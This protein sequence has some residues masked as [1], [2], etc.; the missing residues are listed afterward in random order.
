MRKVHATSLSL[1]L[2]LLVVGAGACGKST[3][4][5]TVSGS[6]GSAGQSGGVSPGSRAG[7]AVGGLSAAAGGE[8]GK[9]GGS[10]AASVTGGTPAS[11]GGA[12]QGGAGSSGTPS[13]VAGSPSLGGRLASGGASAAVPATGGVRASG[14][15]VAGTPGSGGGS[16]KGGLVANGG[17]R[18]TG[19]M[20]AAGGSTGGATGGGGSAA[21]GATG[22]AGNVGTPNV[23]LDLATQYQTIEGFGF[24]GAQDNWWGSASDMW[25]DDWGTFVIN[26][27]GL[28]MW[29]NEY[30]SEEPNQDANWAK[31]KPVVQGFKKIADANRVPLKFILTVWSAP[32]S[33]KCTV[34]SVQAGQNPCTA[35][36]DGLKNGGT[37]DPTKYSAYADWL[38]QG[39]KNYADA[40][41]D[42]YAISPQ[43]E[44]MFVETYNSCVYDVDPTKLNSY[45]KMIE[46]VAPLVK[47]TYPNVKI[48]GQ[49]NMLGLEGQQW[50]Y[51]GNMDSPGWPNFDVLA[52]H[53]YQ[54]GV[55]PTAGSQLATYWAYVR[56][57]WAVPHNKNSWMTETSGYT[58]GW[59][60][61][62]GAKALGFAIYAA[63]NYGRASAWV[64][65]QG[66]ELGGPPNE[67]G[68][69]G[70]LQYLSKRYFVSKSFYRYIRPGAKMVKVTS[71]DSD[72]FVVAF[73]HPTMN[74]TTLVAI[75]NNTKQDKALVL[76]G[77]GIPS[78]YS[79]FRT[80]AT[81]N[82][83][84]L[85]N[86]S[87]GSITLKADSITTLVNGPYVE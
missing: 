66:S 60:D 64:W 79:A 55:A 84:A 3:N 32:S 83:V 85:G 56:D 33:M 69:M 40:G 71:T 74:A 62:Q 51:C 24:F 54:D 58:D 46:A 15:A 25:S 82:G 75:N 16:G 28:T 13:S 19:G 36:P 86:V 8:Q 78:T 70:G 14:G 76:G 5:S 21:G 27:L 44:P 48:F 73:V 59:A 20:L 29:R 81:E 38:K 57:N 9:G 31:Q 77:A 65:W 80:S 4:Y 12:A 1:T 10:A 30:Y 22:T 39:I 61:T 37:L 47:A 26:D 49:E 52:Y 11:G 68:L 34:A 2:A 67:Y 72:L 35:N 7:A 53:G 42:L 17:A 6:G 63:L 18:A 43:N 41:V 87:N 50:F 45:S 23:T